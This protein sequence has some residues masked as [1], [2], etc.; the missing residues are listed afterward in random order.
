M[1]LVWVRTIWLGVWLTCASIAQAGDADVRGM[2]VQWQEEGLTLRADIVAEL[3]PRMEEAVTRGVPLYF[4]LETQVLRPRWYWLDER[5]AEHSE[6]YRLSW[7]ALTRKYRLTVGGL[8]RNFA[9]LEEAMASLLKVRGYALTERNVVR[10]GEVV[11]VMFRFSLDVSR[12]PKPLQV[13]AI[14]TRD[15]SLTTDWVRVLYPEVSVR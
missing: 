3:T 1:K 12:L 13:S 14:G 10:P 7:H 8:H 15:W 9:S 6:V 5:I 4:T 2:Q 11:Q